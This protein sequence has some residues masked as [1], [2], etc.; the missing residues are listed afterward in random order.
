MTKVNSHIHR[1]HDPAPYFVGMFKMTKK[2]TDE[3]YHLSFSNDHFKLESSNPSDTIEV[4]TFLRNKKRKPSENIKK[5]HYY[6]CE[7]KWESHGEI[8]DLEDLLDLE[9]AKKRRESTPTIK[10]DHLLFW[11]FWDDD[12]SCWQRT[13]IYACCNASSHQEAAEWMLKEITAKGSEAHDA[14]YF[15]TGTLEIIK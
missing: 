11:I 5:E 15:K 12:F 13:P 6:V 1:F 4:A 14:D 10:T 7:F 3:N 2:E 8:K 9:A